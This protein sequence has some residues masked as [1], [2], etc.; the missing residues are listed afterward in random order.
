MVKR[1]ALME[2]LS[3]NLHSFNNNRDSHRF[4]T[5]SSFFPFGQT[6]TCPPLFLDGLPPSSWRVKRQCKSPI[7]S[8]ILKTMVLKTLHKYIRIYLYTYISVQKP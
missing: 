6:K 7:K 4:S 3:S 2:S 5:N 1:K 8:L